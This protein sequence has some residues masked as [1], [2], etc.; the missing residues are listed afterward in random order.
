[1]KEMTDLEE[2]AAHVACLTEHAY[3]E[4]TPGV[5]HLDAFA[6]AERVLEHHANKRL[7]LPK[8]LAWARAIVAARKDSA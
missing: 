6:A 8:T 2:R 5:V 3:A 1:M 4:T 7:Y